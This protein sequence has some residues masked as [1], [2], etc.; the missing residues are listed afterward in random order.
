METSLK[1]LDFLDSFDLLWSKSIDKYDKNQLNL[2]L[3]KI[4]SNE[5][6]G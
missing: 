4:N 1:E 5:S 6:N 2:F 3:L